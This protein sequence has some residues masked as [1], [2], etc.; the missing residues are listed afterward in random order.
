MRRVGAIGRVGP[1]VPLALALAAV[2][3]PPVAA[4]RP[5]WEDVVVTMGGSAEEYRGNLSSVSVPVVDSTDRA[6]AAVGELGLR[7]SLVLLSYADGRDRAALSFDGGLRQFAATGFELR[8]Y[9][10]REW[11]GRLGA[12]WNEGIG[13]LGRASL[14]LGARTRS[15]SDRPPMPLF[16]Q[17]GFSSYSGTGVFR[18]RA[19]QGVRFDAQVEAEWV[20]YRAGRLVPQ[21]DLL[22]RRF[23]GLEVG[24]E[25]GV[26]WT[27][28]FYGG[29]RWSDYRHQASFDPEDPY[30]RDHAFHAGA[31]WT[32][33]GPV[34][35]QMGIEGTLNRSNSRRPEYDAVALR[36]LVSAPLPRD[37]GLNLFANITGKNYLHDTDFAR[38]V[39]GEEADN[40]SIVYVD[41]SR[42]LAYDLD[43]ALRL[44]WTR[45]ETDI[46]TSYFQRFGV[47][48][49]LN[50]RPGTY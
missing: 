31:T 34:I 40:A 5:H 16:L 18:L 38:L 10:P 11:V 3:A 48:F 20:D 29:Y 9:A 25:W 46:G 35:A 41:V 36:A 30:R 37:F 14:Q 8:D 4:Q 33:Q 2:L 7:G 50:Y 6:A 47:T 12:T 43:G 27:I 15:V 49:L 19:I 23:E 13:D 45:A 44:G 24:A 32:W 21:L 42:P 22:D 26:G 17:P 28:R 39:P 1:V